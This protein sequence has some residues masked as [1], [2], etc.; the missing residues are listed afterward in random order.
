MQG[1]H[2]C[3][4]VHMGVEEGGGGEIEPIFLSVEATRWN[5]RPL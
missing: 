3:P 5:D 4:H 1:R 2:Q